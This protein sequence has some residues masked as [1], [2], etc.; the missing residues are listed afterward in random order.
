EEYGISRTPLREALK[1]LAAEGLI[2]MKVRRG[3]YVTEVSERDLAD[4]YHLLSL[5]EGDAA[6]T[7]AATAT[8]VQL[9]EL[10]AIHAQ[11]Q[12]S[13]KSPRPDH[14]AF[15]ALNIAFHARLLEI[16]NNRWRVQM[17]AD[18]R[19]IIKLKGHSSLFKESRARQ[20]LHEHDALMKAI[21]ARDAPAAMQ[22]MQEHFQSGLKAATGV[23]V[24]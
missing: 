21:A 22:R 23:Q 19:K 1:V 6:A 9:S 14:A 17:V 3:A 2:T 20:S 5:L 7:V 18:L 12:A 4:V 16:A 24:P 8:E 11:L 10:E 15:L 13:L